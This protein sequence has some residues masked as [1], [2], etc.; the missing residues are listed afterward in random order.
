M[1]GGI[2]Y[3][4]YLAYMEHCNWSIGNS[5]NGVTFRKKRFWFVWKPNAEA[6]ETESRKK[7]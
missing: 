3:K 5:S 2:I 1:I 7:Q 4:N 6:Q